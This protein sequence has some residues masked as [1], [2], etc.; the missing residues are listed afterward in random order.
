MPLWKGVAESP[1][2]PFGPD[3][4]APLVRPACGEPAA[5]GDGACGARTGW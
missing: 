1:Q 3:Y 4:G 2:G 5:R